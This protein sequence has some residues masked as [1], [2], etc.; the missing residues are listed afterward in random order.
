MPSTRPATIANP[1][2]SNQPSYRGKR[3]QIHTELPQP[4]PRRRKLLLLQRQ[5]QSPGN[6]MRPEE[7]SQTRHPKL[8]G[9]KSPH[10]QTERALQPESTRTR[11]VQ[12]WTTSPMANYLTHTSHRKHPHRRRSNVKRS[13]T[14]WTDPDQA[15]KALQRKGKP[16]R[17]RHLCRPLRDPVVPDQARNII[18]LAKPIVDHSNDKSNP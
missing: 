1:T 10:S 5:Q 17:R 8:I 15:W 16:S 3:P 11:S 2:R 14:T 18:S 7:H 6:R 13:R 4:R 12:T 9:T